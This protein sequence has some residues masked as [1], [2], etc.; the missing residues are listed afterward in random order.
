MMSYFPS[1]TFRNCPKSSN[2]ITE[3]ILR[4]EGYNGIILYGIN[5]DLEFTLLREDTNCEEK[6]FTVPIGKK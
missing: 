6:I 3:N 4:K 2:S 1:V 5:T